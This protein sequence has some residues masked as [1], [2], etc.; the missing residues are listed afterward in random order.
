M[1]GAVIRV[2]LP[3]WL[4]GLYKTW[5]AVSQLLWM[6]GFAGYLVTYGKTLLVP[7]ASAAYA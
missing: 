7:N 1:A 6:V 2:L 3:W 4:P 5:I